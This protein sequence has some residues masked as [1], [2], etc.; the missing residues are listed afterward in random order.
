[1]AKANSNEKNNHHFEMKK[2]NQKIQFKKIERIGGGRIRGYTIDSEDKI[3][4]DSV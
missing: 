3:L 2:V 1:V 4:V